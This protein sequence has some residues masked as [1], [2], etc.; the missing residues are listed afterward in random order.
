[1]SVADLEQR[2]VLNEPLTPRESQVVALLSQGI[3]SDRAIAERLVVTVHTVKSHVNSVMQ[4]FGLR[5]RAQIVAYAL[6]HGSV[7]NSMWQPDKED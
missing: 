3:D 7:V 2:F 5:S 6:T 4:K 1:M